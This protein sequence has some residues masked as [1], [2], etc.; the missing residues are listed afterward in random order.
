MRIPFSIRYP[1]EWYV[2]EP[3]DDVPQEACA[4]ARARVR[5]RGIFTDDGLRTY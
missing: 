4:F 5:L 3:L 1:V 2:L